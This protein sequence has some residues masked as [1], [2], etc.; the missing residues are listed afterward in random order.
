METSQV[1][2]EG[3]VKEKSADSELKIEDFLNEQQRRPIRVAAANNS[4]I[5]GDRGTGTDLIELV[6]EYPELYDKSHSLYC[7]NSHKGVVWSKIAKDLGCSSAKKTRE[8]FSYMRKRFK[9][10][11]YARKQG[12]RRPLQPDP[13]SS[14]Y[15]QPLFVYEQL[16]FLEPA[17]EAE[18]ANEN[19]FD[20]D[21]KIKDEFDLDPP[22]LEYSTFNET[23]SRVDSPLEAEIANENDFDDDF[24]IKDEFDLDPP[25]LEY[26]TFNET[27]SRVDS[28]SLKRKRR[29]PGSLPS[30]TPALPN[31]S[32]DASKVDQ[33][34][35]IIDLMKSIVEKNDS[36]SEECKIFGKQVAVDLRSLNM[37]NRAIA[38]YQINKVLMELLLKEIGSD[39]QIQ[40]L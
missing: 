30:P 25:K 36:E 5:F 21:F 22:K 27:F 18:I 14:N 35:Q 31:P 11:Y 29:T 10:E 34:Q 9:A 7:N 6:R 2:D 33:Q 13:D 28:P 16:Q 8:Q 24:K 23:F 26:S 17:L 20:D 1:V 38:R 3:N 37:K 15:R 32:I 19:D 12:L 40:Q 39:T 4:A